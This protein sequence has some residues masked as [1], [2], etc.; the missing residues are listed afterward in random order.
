MNHRLSD[1]AMICR[2]TLSKHFRMRG[3]E[4]F[5][6][7]WWLGGGLLSISS[8][9]ISASNAATT[10]SI[11]IEMV[12]VPSGSFVMGQDIGGDGDE[13]PAHKVKITQ[14]FLMSVTEVTLEQY[15]R[16][17][18]EHKLSTDGKATGV[19][20]HEASAFC[21]W[22]S[23][24]ESKPYRLP[25][26]AEWEYACRAGTTTPF[27]SGKSP[28]TDTHAANPW[29]LKSMH[30]SVIEWCYDWYGPYAAN[31]QTDP[32]GCEAGMVKVV[33]GGKPD[34]NERVGDEVGLKPLDYHRSANRT[35]L[36]PAFGNPPEGV[37]SEK[38][39]DSDTA[40]VGFRIVQTPLPKTQPTRVTLPFV[41][42]CIHL[43][44][45]WVKHAPATNRPYFRK[46]YLLPIP[47]DN[48]PDEEIAAAGLPRSFRH[49]NHSPGLEVCPNGDLLLIIYTSYREYEP[50]VSLMAARLRYGSDQ[51]DM[52]EPMFDCPD[53]NDH[54]PMLWTDWQS[55][56]RMYFFWGSPRLAVGGFPFQWM[57]SDDS[58]ADWSEVHFP[59]FKGPI[60]PHSRQP[61]NTAVRGLDGTLYISSDAIG[62]T[63]VLWATPD[64]GQ[65][66]F[67]T[68]GRSA[69]RHTTYCLLKDGRILGMGG[70]NTDIDGYM[71]KAISADGGKT[72][73]VS[74]TPFCM[75]ANNQR[76]SLVRLQS[77]RLFFAGD[78]QRRD[79]KQ[80]AG[81]KEKGSYVALSDDEGET[82]HIKRIPVA[83]PHEKDN[84]APT[85][86]YS[87]ARQAPNGM[88]HSIT[89]MNTPCLHFELNEA[90]I[91]SEADANANDADLMP[92]KTK[93]I[94]GLK[95][96]AE[97]YP[98]GQVKANWTAGVGDD[99][100]YL[101]HGAETWYF[102][103][104][105]KHH[106]ANYKL[107][108]KVGLETLWRPDGSVEWQWTHGRD[109]NSRWTQ[110][111]DNGQKK[112]ESHWRDFHANGS[113]KCWNRNGE[114]VSA[115]NFTNGDP[116]PKV[117]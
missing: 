116:T 15:R 44:G 4:F 90:W 65:T 96:H 51:W 40:G 10:N 13:A 36:A 48:S 25:T 56:G 3:G 81:I 19:S 41:R 68:S 83:Q 110:Y 69:G 32:I 2:Y 99:G 115:V 105:K 91:L 58:G 29:G 107:G 33:R 88:I 109:G 8:I 12:Q 7:F 53:A 55:G 117:R 84:L 72:W 64:N 28:P 9:A 78:F 37:A 108:Q 61:I 27:S 67:D 16:F 24:K 39:P 38:A 106:E 71:P 94:A 102:E 85:L 112:S 104:G 46:R 74:K 11:G 87:A 79:G 80:P 76:P 52:P 75:Q 1:L 77:G 95:S 92:S 66:W 43:P 63:S 82:W 14:P 6:F 59:Q 31:E 49:H 57:T 86:G 35:G 26:E 42:Q 20:W 114:L 50:G 18:P 22:L 93:S 60:G 54:A 17:K 98:S 62:G 34:D 73:T 101:L 111:W 100:R 97:E 30:N 89:T 45:D 113:A 21:E 23:K 47:P 5:P 103:N 70:K